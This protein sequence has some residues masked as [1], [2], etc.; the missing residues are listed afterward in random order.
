[1]QVAPFLDIFVFIKKYYFADVQNDIF[2]AIYENYLKELYE[3]Q[4]LGQYFTD[5]AVVNFML[6]EIGYSASEIKKRGHDNMSPS[7]CMGFDLTEVC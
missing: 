1:M 2:G 7:L 3:E 6:E 5:P 4:Q